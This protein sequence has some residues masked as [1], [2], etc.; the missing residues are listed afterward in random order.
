[1]GIA[2]ESLV[3]SHDAAEYA[4]QLHLNTRGERPLVNKARRF[5]EHPYRS[6]RLFAFK[7]GFIKSPEARSRA[8]FGTILTLPLSDTNATDIYYVGRLRATEG[9]VTRFLLKVLRNDSVFYDIGANYGFYSALA[10]SLGAELHAFEPSTHCMRFLKL[11]ADVSSG[12]GT[13]NQVALSDSEGAVDFFD[14]SLGHKSGMS[15]TNERVALSTAVAHQKSVV[16]ALT[17]DTYVQCH[18]AP[19][20]IKIDVEGGESKVLSGARETL[21]RY[22]PTLIVE[23]WGSPVGMENS[24]DTLALL[25]QLGYRSHTI[26][27]DGGIH[28]VDIDLATIGEN[29]NFVFTR[30]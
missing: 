21:R 14:T 8:F 20:V 10:L 6:L 5:L 12:R 27:P 19:T 29:N 11:N 2:Q 16:P 1:M 13:L 3:Q 18:I 23:L 17:L 24:R 22:A 28:P 7:R 25:R 26:T 4:L 9:Y 30:L 15:T